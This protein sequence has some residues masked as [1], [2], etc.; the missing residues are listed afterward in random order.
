MPV[1]AQLANADQ[2]TVFA[3]ESSVVGVCGFLAAV[4]AG[5]LCERLFARIPA[6]SLYTT[7]IGSI[8]ASV[9]MALA[10]YSAA[11]VQ[12]SDARYRLS[13]AGSSLHLLAH[14][15]HQSASPKRPDCWRHASFMIAC[16]TEQ[17]RCIMHFLL[18]CTIGLVLADI[19]MLPVKLQLAS[20]CCY[21]ADTPC[22]WPF[23]P[24]P[25]CAL[26]AGLGQSPVWWRLFSP[27]KSSPLASPS[28]L[29]SRLS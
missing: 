28:G 18:L 1:Y 20:I 16:S 3:A 23:W 6:I 21:G 26:R 4:C 17:L 14:Y 27:Q 24:F 12:A 9:F 29:R 11:M 15:M 10:V 2:S 13:D 19:R 8:A 7:S 22:S 25:F 5:V